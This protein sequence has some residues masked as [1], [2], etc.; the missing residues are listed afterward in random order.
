MTANRIIA[1]VL[2]DDDFA[3]Y[4]QNIYEKY[5]EMAERELID[6]LNELLSSLTYL[7]LLKQWSAQCACRFIGY[8]KITIRLKSG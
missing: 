2:G 6:K 1:A 4:E 7:T 3:Q 5:Q 8:R